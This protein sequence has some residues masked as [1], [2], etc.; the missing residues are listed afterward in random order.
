FGADARIIEAGGNGVNR[1]GLAVVVLQH[2][3]VAAVQDAGRAETER[4]GVVAKFAGPATGL[5]AD[6]FDLAIFDEREKHAAR[7]AAAA[8]A[9]DDDF[10]KLADLFQA[11]L[12]RFLADH[13]LKIA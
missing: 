5:D 3:A 6:Q 1:G 12:A 7:V 13:R 11:L 9:G 4:G 10:G 2:I 8:H